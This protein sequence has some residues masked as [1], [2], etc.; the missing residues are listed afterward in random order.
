MTS[1]LMLTV[2]NPD[3]ETVRVYDIM[4]RQL[5]TSRLSTATIH[6]P[7]PGVYLVRIGDRPAKKVVAVR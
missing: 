5:A 1:G 3:G 7:V 4:G 6:L 2:D